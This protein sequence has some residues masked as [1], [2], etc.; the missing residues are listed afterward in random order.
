MFWEGLILR[1][2]YV[3]LQTHDP[4][5]FILITIS[6]FQLWKK[7]PSMERREL[8]M[9]FENLLDPRPTLYSLILVK[10]LEPSG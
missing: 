4:A 6:V 2:K 9:E 1:D 8:D 7:W 10:F 3:I 5:L